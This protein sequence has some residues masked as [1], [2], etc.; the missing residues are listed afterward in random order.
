MNIDVTKENTQLFFVLF[1][2]LLQIQSRG[3][4][5]LP[6]KL[7]SRGGGRAREAWTLPQIEFPLSFTNSSSQLSLS[8]VAY[9]KSIHKGQIMKSL[10][11]S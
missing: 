10:A 7:Y 6:W 2:Q 1:F 8:R 4:S 11:I 5:L 3:T 9:T